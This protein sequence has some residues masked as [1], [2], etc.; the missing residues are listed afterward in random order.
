MKPAA[1]HLE[2]LRGLEGHLRDRLRGQDHVIAP[3]AALFRRGELGLVRPD[4]PRGVFLAIGPTGT[5]KTELVLLCARHLFGDTAIRRID[6][7]EFQRADAVERLLGADGSDPGVLGHLLA[8]SAP[9]VLLF[10]ELEKAHAKVFDLFIQMLDPGHVTVATGR[11]IQLQDCYIAFTSNLGA[12]EAARMTRSSLASVEAAVLR[13]L[14][15][16]LRPE[17]LARIPDKYVFAAL[18]PDVQREIGELHLQAEVQRLRQHGF[19]LEVTRAAAEYLLR[20]GME[21]RL[22]ARR[23]RQT[24]ERHLQDAVV[25]QLFAHG[26]GRGRV[27]L[28]ADLNRLKVELA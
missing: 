7:S 23:L 11:R 17:F 22:G 9:C 24:I 13:R 14:G 2:R 26:A 16:T 8:G 4:R 21:T 5:G 12:G 6:L 1:E 20:E 19:D 15:E 25:D 18:T 28:D 3:A 10:D 27:V